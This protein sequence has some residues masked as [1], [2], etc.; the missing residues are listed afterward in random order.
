MIQYSL[1][2]PPRILAALRREAASALPGECCGA[3]MGMAGNPPAA[4][5]RA[6]IPVPNEDSAHDRYRIDAATVLK[7]ERQASCAGLQL[8]GFYHSHP[9][10]NAAPSSLDLELAAP[11]FL[12]VIVQPQDGA[13]RAWRLRDDRRGFQELSLAQAVS[14]A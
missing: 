12:Y 13:I 6:L 9:R 3:L 14:A 1:T 5:I 4:E 10:G 2:L 7:L 11:G 8:L